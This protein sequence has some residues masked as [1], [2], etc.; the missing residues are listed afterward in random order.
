LAVIIKKN[1]KRII[2][3]PKRLYGYI[4]VISEGNRRISANKSLPIIPLII[5]TRIILRI[6][7]LTKSRKL[8]DTILVSGGNFS[9][10]GNS[11]IEF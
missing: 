10:N 6:I 2:K 7:A 11:I 1:P 4:K 9:F 3:S 8:F 5:T